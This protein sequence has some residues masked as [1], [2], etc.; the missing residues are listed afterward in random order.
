MGSGL[1]KRRSQKAGE[2]PWELCSGELFLNFVRHVR[3]LQ[4]FFFV[5]TVPGFSDHNWR[6]VSASPA[7]TLSHYDTFIFSLRS[8][9]ELP[10]AKTRFVANIGGSLWPVAAWFVVCATLLPGNRGTSS[11]TSDDVHQNRVL[12]CTF[13]H[14]NPHVFLDTKFSHQESLFKSMIWILL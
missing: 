11:V 1:K 5:C 14:P 13:R 2:V 7:C 9:Y 4:H 3:K 6:V 8:F 10:L 12:Y